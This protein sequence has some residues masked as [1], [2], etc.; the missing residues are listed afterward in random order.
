MFTPR[1]SI[2]CLSLLIC[3]S[4]TGCDAMMYKPFAPGNALNKDGNL[5]GA[6]QPTADELAAADYG[7]PIDQEH[8]QQQVT[9]WMTYR[10]KDADSAKYQWG[11]VDRG[12]VKDAPIIGGH[13]YTGYV[14]HALVN[15]KNSYGGYSGFEE[16]TFLFRDG[17]IARAYHQSGIPIQ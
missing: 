16:Y 6:K 11:T 2:V 10:L 9:A 5:M 1:R 7:A 17:Q 12:F 8:A 15:A 4:L 3:G 13:I 14:L